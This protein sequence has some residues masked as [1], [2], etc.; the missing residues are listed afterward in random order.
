MSPK[1]QLFKV[2]ELEPQA[3][4]KGIQKKKQKTKNKTRVKLN[5][6]QLHF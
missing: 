3:L 1:Q 2:C 6:T 4:K 5:S